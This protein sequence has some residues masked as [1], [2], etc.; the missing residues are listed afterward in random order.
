MTRAPSSQSQGNTP[1]AFQG[2]TPSAVDRPQT[3]SDSHSG[4]DSSKLR[5]KVEA[6]RERHEDFRVLGGK[7]K[8]T[9]DDLMRER[10]YHHHAGRTE[11]CGRTPL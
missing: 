9:R 3:S 2:R 6:L 10:G 11:A 1:G 7:L 5:A 8:H 4:V